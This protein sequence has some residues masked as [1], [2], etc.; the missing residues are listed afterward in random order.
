MHPSYLFNQQPRMETIKEIKVWDEETFGVY[1]SL[2]VVYMDGEATELAN[3]SSYG[4]RAPI[5]T[6]H[7]QRGIDV[8]R[9]LEVE[10]LHVDA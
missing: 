4:L 5:H 9:K 10:Q 2:L 6:S 1:V 3:D 7:M 8:T